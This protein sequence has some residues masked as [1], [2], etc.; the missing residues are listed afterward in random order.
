METEEIINKI[1][2]MKN[3]VS[4][5]EPAQ[6]QES[7]GLKAG[8]KRYK[9]VYERELCIGAVA[10]VMDD[11]KYWVMDDDGK[12]NL[13]GGKEVSPG[14]FEIE[15]SEEDFPKTLEAAK[16]CPVLCIHIIDKKTGEKII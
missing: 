15:L 13:I 8:E 5:Q 7:S 2:G 4:R 16:D 14:I 10:C 9:V 6:T 1:K 3:D 12:A 11:P